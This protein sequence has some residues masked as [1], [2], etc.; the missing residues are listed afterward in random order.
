MTRYRILQRLDQDGIWVPDAYVIERS[1]G[2][3][4]FRYPLSWEYLGGRWNRHLRENHLTLNHLDRAMDLGGHLR[5][6]PVEVTDEDASVVV[7]RLDALCHIRRSLLPEMIEVQGR[8]VAGRLTLSPA[9]QVPP[10]VRVEGNRIQLG[11]RWQVVVT[12]E[13]TN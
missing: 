8:V 4:E 2:Q 10:D 12:L 1:D 3:I 6:L 5:W 13:S 7:D 11:D 9:Q